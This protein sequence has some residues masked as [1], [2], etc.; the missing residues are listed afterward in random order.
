MTVFTTE[1]ITAKPLSGVR[2]SAVSYNNQIKAEAVTGQDG[3]CR[4]PV[5]DTYY[6][7]GETKNERSVVLLKNPFNPFTF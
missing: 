4:L 6:V 5:K 7:T 2:V 1:F 3:Q